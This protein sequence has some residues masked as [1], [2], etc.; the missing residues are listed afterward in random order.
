MVDLLAESHAMTVRQ[1][2]DGMPLEPDHLYIIPPGTYLAV[3]DGALHLSPPPARHG[4]RLPF[5]FLLHSLGRGSAA[6]APSA[7]CCRE[8]AP[9]AA[10]GCRRSRR[11]GGLVIAQEPEEA[12][13][14]GMPRSAIM[15]GRGRPRCCRSTKIPG[16]ADRRRH[17]GR[18]G[19]P[20]TAT[21]AGQRPRTGCP[22]SSTCCAPRPHTISR[23]YKPGTLRAPDRAAHGDGGDRRRTDIGALSRRSCRRRAERARPAGQGP[24][25]QRHQ[26][27]PRSGGV[28][29][30][31]GEDRSRHGRAI[32]RPISRSGSGS[33]AAAP[34]RR[35]IPWPCCS[36]SRSP[37]RSSQRQAAG[38]RL[39]RRSGRDRARAREGL[40]PEAIEADVRPSGW[41]LFHQ[42]RSRLPDLAG[43]AR[44]RGLHGAGR[45]GRSALLAPRPGIVPEPADLSAPEAQAKVLSLFHFALRDG[46]I[47]LLGSSETV[48]SRQTVSRSSPSRSG[49]YRHIGQSRPGEFGFAADRWRRRARRRRGRDRARRRRARPRW[50]T[51]AGD[52]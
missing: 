1:A 23:L 25:D 37:G 38:L 48:G 2:A 6:R 13:Y 22:R 24:A 36:A 18:P 26:L 39:R 40:Y 45:A 12:G 43:A 9:T 29:S 21:T 10:L 16:G 7:W 51:F 50:P 46:G 3:D 33:P 19:R 8:P 14:D 42:G 15:T 17:A 5:D 28:R 44:R 30:A 32:T 47:L 4:A 35:P 49:I 52:W 34:A 27:L 41:P 11:Q 20:G 31:G